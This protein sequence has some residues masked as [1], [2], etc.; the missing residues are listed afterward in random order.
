[1]SYQVPSIQRED[2]LLCLFNLF[3]KNNHSIKSLKTWDQNQGPRLDKVFSNQNLR[4]L[5]RVLMFQRD[6]KEIHMDLLR[7]E[8]SALKAKHSFNKWPTM[9]YPQI[10]SSFQRTILSNTSL[11]QE[12]KWWTEPTPHISPTPRQL[13]QSWLNHMP[14]IL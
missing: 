8:F 10:T 13:H 11:A 4:L 3:R 14:K 12:M 2:Q 1:M 6:F 5:L 7:T 9:L